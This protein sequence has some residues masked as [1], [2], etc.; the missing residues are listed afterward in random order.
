MIIIDFCPKCGH[1]LREIVIC[2]YPPIDRKECYRCGWSWESAPLPII[3]PTM[4]QDNTDYEC[5]N[6][7][8]C[9]ANNLAGTIFKSNMI[10]QENTIKLSHDDIMAA[11][12]RTK[13]YIKDK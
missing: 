7:T 10:T 2:T 6:S 8:D 11:V 3:K 4:I 12:D 1:E 9:F 5:L 13:K